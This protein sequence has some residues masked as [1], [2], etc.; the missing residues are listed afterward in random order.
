MKQE[1]ATI[2]DNLRQSA[3]IP[4]DIVFIR[5]LIT[6]KAITIPGLT[7][8]NEATEHLT[9]SEAIQSTMETINKT[10]S[11]FREAKMSTKLKEYQKF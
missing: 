8:G 6:G 1:K 7:I 2:C 9:N 10:I 11:K 4:E 3:T 5:S